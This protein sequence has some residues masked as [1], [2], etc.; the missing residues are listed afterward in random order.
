[1]ADYIIICLHVS[2]RTEKLYC[3]ILQFL[4]CLYSLT[5]ILIKRP[6]KGRFFVYGRKSGSAGSACHF[7]YNCDRWADSFQIWQV[8]VYAVDLGIFF[9]DML[10]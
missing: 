2:A 7:S 10:Q 6:A 5:P 3:Q 8:Y 1:M 9:F 4:Y